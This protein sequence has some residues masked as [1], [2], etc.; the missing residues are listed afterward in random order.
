MLKLGNDRPTLISFSRSKSRV[1]CLGL[2]VVVFC[3]FSWHIVLKWNTSNVVLPLHASNM[4]FAKSLT[5]FLSFFLFLFFFLF[6]LAADGFKSANTIPLHSAP[7]HTHPT[8]TPKAL[9]IFIIFIWLN[10]FKGFAATLTPSL[11]KSEISALKVHGHRALYHIY[12]QRYT[13]WWKSF[14]IPVRK[15]KQKGLKDKSKVRGDFWYDFR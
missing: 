12:F 3:L 1:M 10:F 13:F 8:F 6:R 14:Y 15:R 7:S 11:P 9:L 4:H 5:F 2:G